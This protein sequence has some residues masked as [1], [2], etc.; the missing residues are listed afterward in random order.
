[1]N[2]GKNQRLTF[3]ECPDDINCMT[4]LAKV[5]DLALVI[6]D[7]SIGFEMATFEFLS[8]L[9]VYIINS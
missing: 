6:I 7:A 8:L 9:R 3:I 1:L 4:D 2:A 5:A